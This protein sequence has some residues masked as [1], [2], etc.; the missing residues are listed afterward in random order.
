MGREWLLTA[1]RDGVSI[2]GDET[3]LKSIVIMVVPLCEYTENPWNR[4]LFFN[5]YSFDFYT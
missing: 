4:T 1:S 3:V 5:D 2:W